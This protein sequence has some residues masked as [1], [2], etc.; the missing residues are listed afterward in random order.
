M[1]RM[2]LSK[3]QRT[4]IYCQCDPHNFHCHGWK[5]SCWWD[6]EYCPSDP[7]LV[8]RWK[9]LHPLW[10]SPECISNDDK[11]FWPNILCYWAIIEFQLFSVE[12][13]FPYF[14]LS[15]SGLFVHKAGLGP[16]YQPITWQTCK[17]PSINY[18]IADREGG[19]WPKD[20]NIT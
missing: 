5:P 12:E 8:G 14:T 2:E 1:M 18:V 13:S 9:T 10:R 17:G 4:E 19:V 11:L 6:E 15:I 20:Y 16:L 3:C 7:T